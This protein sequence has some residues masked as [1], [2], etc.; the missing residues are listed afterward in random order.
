MRASDEHIILFKEINKFSNEPTLI[1]YDGYD[2]CPN[3]SWTTAFK[4]KILNRL[5]EKKKITWFLTA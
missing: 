2:C 3:W 4:Y 5:L 1:Y